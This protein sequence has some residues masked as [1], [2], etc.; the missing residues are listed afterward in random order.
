MPANELN[1]NWALHGYMI[2]ALGSFWFFFL[3]I[4]H[5]QTFGGVENGFVV[6][7]CQTPFTRWA[8]PNVQICS[9]LF[10][11]EKKPLEQCASNTF[12]IQLY[13]LAHFNLDCRVAFFRRASSWNKIS[14]VLFL[15]YCSE[16]TQYSLFSPMSSYF[17]IA[18]LYMLA[19]S[20][21]LLF[22]ITRLLNIHI[23][24]M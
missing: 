18:R 5:Q 23:D 9:S 10:V 15:F 20:V 13:H 12:A 3:G 21:H 16:H 17:H 24:S 14:Y 7:S 22:S 1:M 8:S 11:R 6:L 4:I 19:I 2:F